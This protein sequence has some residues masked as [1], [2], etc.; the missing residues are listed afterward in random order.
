M[1]ALYR[2]IRSRLNPPKPSHASFA[3]QTILITAATGGLGLE[4][5]QKLA[6]QGTSTLIITARDE[7][8]AAIAK[9][10]IE[11][12]LKSISP[13]PNKSI[14]IVSLVLEM[15]EPS[16]IHAFI[17]TL[18]THTKHLDHAILNAGVVQTTHSMSA[19]YETTIRVNTVSTTLLSLLVLPFLLASP[20]TTQDSVSHRPHLSFISSGTAWT[21]KLETWKPYSSDDKPMAALSQP[22]AFTAFQQYARSKLL[23][24]M[25]I[26]PIAFLPSL[27][28]DPSNAKSQ[29]KVLVTSTCPGM[30]RTDLARGYTSKGLVISILIKMLTFLISR[31]AQAG[32]NTHI[33]SL[34]TGMEARG[35]MWKD[36]RVWLEESETNIRGKEAREVGGRAWKEMKAVVEAEDG[37]GVVS[38]MLTEGK[39]VK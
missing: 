17:D 11:A 1:S 25:C 24:E 16:S 20:L 32:A 31:S 37:T 19:S 39:K 10:A 12:H 18:K 6:V 29:L 7:K 9:A 36:D 23:L 2:V 13:N 5:A 3:G 22:E 4:A 14:K 30:T 28:S 8:K 33:T 38:E 15:S 35:E 27:C 21:T 26:R 34:E